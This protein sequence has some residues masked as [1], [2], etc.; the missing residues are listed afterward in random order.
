[1]NVT[2]A[3]VIGE[4][5]GA[6]DGVGIFFSRDEPFKTEMFVAAILNGIPAALLTGLSLTGSSTW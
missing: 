6:L 3:L 1:M 2:V 5:V 4:A